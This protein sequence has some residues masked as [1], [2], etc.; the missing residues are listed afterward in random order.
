MCKRV[1]EEE[2]M[3]LFGWLDRRY[4]CHPFS[5]SKKQESYRIFLLPRAQI[6]K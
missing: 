1:K 4:E 5:R 6:L 2:S 3:L